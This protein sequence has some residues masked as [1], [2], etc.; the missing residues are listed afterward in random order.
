MI[1]EFYMTGPR[2]APPPQPPRRRH[3]G[4][5][6]VELL[7]VIG[8]I[9][10]LVAILTPVVAQVRIRAQSANTQQQMQRIMAACQNYYHDFNT[11][12]GP[13]PERL[14]AG[15]S[16]TGAGGG[17]SDVQITGQNINMG[18][19]TSSENLVLGLIGLLTPPMQSGQQINYTP[20]PP[21]HDVLNLNPLR[22]TSYHY[23]DYLSDELTDGT[24]TGSGI[25]E[26]KDKFSDPIIGL[27]TAGTPLTAGGPIL[28]LRAR[29]GATTINGDTKGNLGQYDPGQLKPYGF[30]NV[31]NLDTSSPDYDP[32]GFAP[33]PNAPGGDLWFTY[34]QNPSL[35]GIPRGKD[36]FMLISAGPDRKYGTQD[37]IIVTP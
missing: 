26:F 9:V 36:S 25:P 15:N 29:V 8:I 22:P 7:V 10:L 16:S 1:K 28:Y 24:L 14:L 5:T 11:Y 6:I 3:G 4:F 19:I 23:I 31:K 27:P 18:K 32:N 12:P 33:A 17:Q 35:A 37:D 2:H 30:A 21:S 13:L 20:P 34:L